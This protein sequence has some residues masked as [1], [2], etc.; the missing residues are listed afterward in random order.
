[1]GRFQKW[2]CV[3]LLGLTPGI[4][5]AGALDS[6]Q[7][8]LGQSPATTVARPARKTKAA[9]NQELAEK[10]AKALRNS[11]LNGY[12]IDIDV[13]DG[14]VILSGFITAVEQ[15]EAATKAVRAVPG[16]VSV[17]NRLRIGEKVRTPYVDQSDAAP[18]RTTDAPGV[19]RLVNYQD[20]EERTAPIQPAVPSGPGPIGT[21]GP[22]SSAPAGSPVYA[23]P[24]AA[25]SYGQYPNYYA[26]TYPAQSAAAAWP[27]M[28]PFHPYPQCPLGWRKV[29][30]QWDEGLWT[31]DF[32]SRKRHWWQ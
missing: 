31:I 17:N 8:R 15:R 25:A 4:A 30:M 19:I 28:G 3:G 6:P 2:L 7:L 5:A 32:G 26:A 14:V 10:I 11:K 16:V 1:M 9:V 18:A 21:T 27:Y 12:D 20:E 22:M 23:P 13:R 29:S 24:A